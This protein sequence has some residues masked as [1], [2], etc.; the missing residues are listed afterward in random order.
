MTPES[1]FYVAP[2]AEDP[3]AGLVDCPRC[4][5]SGLVPIPLGVEDDSCLECGGYG[6]YPRDTTADRPYDCESL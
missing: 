6:V 1:V 3:L 5:G 2:D 4:G